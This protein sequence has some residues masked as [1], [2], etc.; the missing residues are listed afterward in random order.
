MDRKQA[1][2]E[3]A[4]AMREGAKL[5]ESCKGSYLEP[6]PEGDIFDTKYRACALGAA[7]YYYIKDDE[8]SIEEG[9]YGD[10]ITKRWPVLEEYSFK[11]QALIDPEYD[12]PKSTDEI[13][14]IIFDLNDGR[15]WARED[16]AAWLERV[17]EE[18]PDD[19]PN[20]R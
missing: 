14:N 13:Q 16:I 10:K 1:L 6:P 17:A 7:L 20:I 11:P 4:F 18:N 8:E 2:K 15:G 12:D 9:L 3:L 5:T 19:D